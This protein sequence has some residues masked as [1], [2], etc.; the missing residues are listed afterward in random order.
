M[1]RRCLFNKAA[2]VA[3]FLGTLGTVASG[4]KTDEGVFGK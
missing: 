3:S 4:P 2:M 1:L